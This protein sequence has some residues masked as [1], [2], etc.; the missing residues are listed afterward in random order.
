MNPRVIDVTTTESF[1]LHLVFSNGEHRVFDCVPY[2]ERGIF[3]QLRDR[4]VF[5]S[6]RVVAGSVE[7]DGDVDVSYDTLYRES[8]PESELHDESLHTGFI[9]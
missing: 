7:W 9:V 1:T 4:H 3:T 2:L 6:A 5:N 8:T